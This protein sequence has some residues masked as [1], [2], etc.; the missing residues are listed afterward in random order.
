MMPARYWLSSRKIIIDISYFVKPCFIDGYGAAALN[1]KRDP[2]KLKSTGSEF[3]L[4]LGRDV[5]GVI[6]E[7]GLNV[8]YF[9]PGDE[10]M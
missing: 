4:T 10:V 3:P 1:V 5:S 8:S 6:M 9:K 2:L 7:C